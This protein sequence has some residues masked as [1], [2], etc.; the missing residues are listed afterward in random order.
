MAAID[1]TAY[2]RYTR[3]LSI[4]E[5]RAYYTPTTAERTWLPTVVRRPSGLLCCATWLK[6]VQH[7]GYFPALEA[8]PSAVVQHLR[9][10]LDLP[11]DVSLVVSPRTR[12]SYHRLIRDHLGLISHGMRVRHL[13]VEAVYQAAQVMDNPADLINAAIDALLSAKAELPAFSTLDRLVE[14]VRTLVNRRIAL[15]VAQ[16]V[17]ATDQ[18]R[19]AALLVAPPDRTRTP[20]NDLKQGARRPTFQHFD[21][22][23]MQLEQVDAL[24]SFATALA[25]IPPRKVQHFAAEARALD[26]GELKGMPNPK[27]LLLVVALIHQTQIHTRDALVEMVRKRI[28]TF[29]KAARLELEALQ[30]AQ[31]GE[32]ERLVTT[33]DAVL[34]ALDEAAAPAPP[35]AVLQ[36]VRAV[37]TKA[38]GAATL[39]QA[40]DAVRACS[41][42]N[43]L[44]LIWKHYHSHR[45]LLFRM[46]AAL[47]FTATSQDTQLVDAV[48]Y[49]KT[50]RTRTALY[51]PTGIDLSF[52]SQAWQS[53]IIERRDGTPMLVR[54]HLE[55]CIF[56]YLAAELQSGDLAVTGSDA[57]A[58]YRD[59]LLSWEACQPLLA[60]YCTAMGLPTTAAAFVSDLRERL[61]KAAETVDRGVPRNQYL[62]ISPNGEPVLKR[63]ARIE[64]PPSAQRLAV[65]IQA[66]MPE[67]HLLDMVHRVAQWTTCTRH[68]G[69]LAGGDP[70]RPAP[71]DDYARLLF[72]YGTNMGP[73]QAARHMRGAINAQTLSLL[74]RRHV[75]SAKLT[76]VSVDVINA[77]HRLTLP[78][79][80]GDGSVAAADGTHVALNDNNALAEYHFRYRA[81]G[82]IAYH[83][84]A[85]NYIAIFSNFIQCAVWEAVYILEGLLENHSD[86]QPHTVHAD[87]QGQSTP[88]FALAHL[89]NIE[90]LPRIRNWR[91]LVFYKP[92]PAITYQHIDALFSDHIDWALLERHWADMMQVVLSIQYGKISSAMVL[93]KLGNESRKNRL[94]QG[95]RELGR[96]I[97]TLFLLRY[98]SD[99]PLRM[100]ITASTNKVESYNGFVKW[101]FFGSEATIMDH[102]PEE[103]A[104][105]I[106]Y[107]DVL[108]NA[109]IL[110]NVYDMAKVITTLIDEGYPVQIRD[111][112]TLSPYSTAHIKRFGDYVLTDEPAP[113]FEDACATM[114]ETLRRPSADST[115]EAA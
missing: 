112:A 66:R 86:V 43:H 15:Q 89:L 22:L 19:L 69:P 64:P 17:A 4:A 33:F 55:V 70:K 110:H 108:A 77:Y 41:S 42:N 58:D 61:T 85:D 44:R 71:L 65:A 72:T 16:R 5:I 111:L 63:S 96:V 73:T 13:A 38:G 115:T 37:L 11:D 27:Q 30:L 18:E 7:L 1:R 74:N 82:A 91:D 100:Q 88:V 92:D 101:L 78:R 25:G 50:L 14:R 8:V 2:P 106:K 97:R 47:S 32:V 87:T 54:K 107:A 81:L 114:L 109:V 67:R 103:G 51:L 52:A 34:V 83:H 59:Q 9:S 39:A 68:F 98:I 31:R 6:A 10:E 36:R 75:T 3:N 29:H 102:D 46:L 90:L 48:A 57:F 35:D 80:W 105:R 23:L 60:P 12:Y 94:Y 26:A 21:N 45:R 113:H 28:A 84:V 104:K 76:A 79:M 49:L 24:G 53:L 56:S 93:R 20:F 62:T 95:F 99:Q 40:C